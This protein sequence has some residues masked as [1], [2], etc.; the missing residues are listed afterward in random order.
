MLASQAPWSRAAE[1]GGELPRF[2]GLGTL[3][4]VVLLA[5]IALLPLLRWSHHWWESNLHRLFV[6]GGAAAVTLGYYLLVA[7]VGSE[8]ISHVLRRA[9]LEEYV[10]F[11]ALLF[12]LYV[13]SGGIAL[14][15]NLPAHPLTNTGLLGL[16][17]LLASFI[18]T[19]GASMLLIRPLLQTNKERERKEHT[20][21]FFIF[22]VSNIGGTLLPIGDPPL[23]LGYLAG[24]PFF[25]TLGLWPE[26]L[27]CSLLLLVIYYVWDRWAYAKETRKVLQLDETVREP[28]RLEGGI[29]ILWLLGVVSAVAFVVPG[30][31]FPLL[32]FTTFPFLRELL[33][34][35][36][37]VLS[38]KTTPARVREQNQFTYAAILEVAALF[39]GIFITMQVPIQVLNHHGAELGLSKPWQFFW[40][41]GLLSSVLDNAPTYMVFFQTAESLTH[42]PGPGVLQLLDGEFV[43][44]KLL[45]GV[46][47]GAVFLGAMTYIGN[48]PNFMVKAIAEQSGMRMPSFFG[49]FFRYAVPILVPIF[50]LITFLFLL[51]PV[52]AGA[53]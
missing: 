1:S 29:N 51:E 19:T 43:L 16:G 42:A 21:V 34:L 26:W 50:L 38:L 30:K 6:S 31:P 5:A 24:V 15:G 45:A 47:L 37:V 49:Y 35:G 33:M 17:T 39:V 40:A 36:C 10:P 52:P 18:G 41:T 3:P 8:G 48:G 4:F 22:L 7:E 2:W 32:G 11:M 28:L 53:P 44:E 46:S 23:F 13:I 12:C 25:W 27:T 20:V 9:L 14:R